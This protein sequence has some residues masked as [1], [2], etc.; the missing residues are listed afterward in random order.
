MTR[1]RTED[2]EHIPGTLDAYDQRLVDA[3][4]RPLKGVACHA[5]GLPVSTCEDM[6][7][8]FKVCVIPLTCGQG[9]IKG[10]CET[11]SDIVGHLGFQSCVTQQ[12]DGAGMAEAFDRG[13]DI[14][15]LADDERFVGINVRTR[16]VSDNTEMTAKG[17]VAGLDLMV[18]G[19]KHKKALV[20][21]CGEVGRAT[22]RALAAMDVVVTVCDINPEPALALQEEIANEQQVTIDID[23]AW[24]S[25]WRGYEAIIDATPASNV[26]DA[27]MITPDTHVAAPGVPCGLSDEARDSLSNRIL[28]DPLQIGV[29]TMVLDACKGTC[30]RPQ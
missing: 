16:Y 4:G 8:S 22:A 25:T 12:S 26:I 7:K 24:P 18:R 2:I 27:S 3:T 29:A 6:V 21:G 30:V 5:T 9:I 13:S 17:F 14:L 23:H 11:V 28:H 19:L 10:F 1:L 20:I 15:L